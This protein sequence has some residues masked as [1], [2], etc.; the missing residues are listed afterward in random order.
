MEGVTTFTSVKL[1]KKRLEILKKTMELRA[2]YWE[3]IQRKKQNKT[4]SE[5]ERFY[6]NGKCCICIDRINLNK[7]NI[8]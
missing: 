4:I 1:I 3:S 6:K 7:L 8:F 5:M 2:A